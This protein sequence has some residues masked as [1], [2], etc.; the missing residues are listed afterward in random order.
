M[1]QER[2]KEKWGLTYTQGNQGKR[3][4]G[5]KGTGE[6]NQLMKEAGRE[7]KLNKIH[8]TKDYQNKIGNEHWDMAKQTQ[9]ES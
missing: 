5:E 1:M 6:Q 3:Q 9:R 8:K 4:L 7:A 2:A